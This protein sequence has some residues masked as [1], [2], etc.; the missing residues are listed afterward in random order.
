[1]RL[2]NT[3][4]ASMY[5]TQVRNAS[6]FVT[7]VP[8]MHTYSRNSPS[9]MRASPNSNMY[10]SIYYCSNQMKLPSKKELLAQASTLGYA[11]DDFE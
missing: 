5:G 3:S 9:N 11:N 7:T 6:A 1:M 4:V 8:P 2:F 10:R